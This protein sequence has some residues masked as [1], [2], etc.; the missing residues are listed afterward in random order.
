MKKE[1][2]R[3]K[4]TELDL[5][6]MQKRLSRILDSLDDAIIA[7]NECHEISFSN[8]QCA[9]LLGFQT[10]DLLGQPIID[11]FAADNRQ[12]SMIF[13]DQMMKNPSIKKDQD[14]NI[15][16]V[17]K[18][19]GNPVSC[20][21]LFGHLEVDHE[22][23]LVLILQ[24]QKNE[25]ARGAD[26]LDQPSTLLFIEGLNQ[27]RQKLQTIEN[28]LNLRLPFETEASVHKDFK[29]LRKTLAHMETTLTNPSDQMEKKR[30]AV[31]AMNLALQYWQESTG[32]TKSDLADQSG[33][34]KVYVSHNGF[35]RTQTLDKYLD[36]SSLPKQ[37]RWQ[38]I[39]ETIDFVLLDCDT[40][41]LDRKKLEERSLQLKFSN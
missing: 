3:R 14:S 20:D 34:W 17:L 23:L 10:T 24:T 4:R 35:E 11:L 13:L 12:D 16:T 9:K 38:K 6:I 29:M 41:S 1:I 5:K 31:E 21:F 8:S 18:K 32:L 28:F 33:I 36:I 39:L 30:L 15:F 19:D 7:V 22:R 27:T 40:P 37:P 2:E 25:A 26:Y